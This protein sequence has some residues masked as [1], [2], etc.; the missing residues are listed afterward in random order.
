[1]VACLQEEEMKSTRISDSQWEE[2]ERFSN[3]RYDT[4]GIK[5]QET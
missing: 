1:M 4:P 5:R 2:N 3:M